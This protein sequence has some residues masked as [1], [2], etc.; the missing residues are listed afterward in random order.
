MLDGESDTRSRIAA[1][2]AAWLAEHRDQKVK[3]LCN[4]FTSRTWK[5]VLERTVEPALAGQISI[6]PLPNRRYDETDWWRSKKGTVAVVNNY[7]ILGFHWWRSG[8]EADIK[9]RTATDFRAAFA[10]ESR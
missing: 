10:G 8:D 9:E 2:L 5:I 6:V 7:I 4:R 1:A 3:V